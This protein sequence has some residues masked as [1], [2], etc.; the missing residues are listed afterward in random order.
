MKKH[1]LV[2]LLGTA[3]SLSACGQMGEQWLN[4]D[5]TFAKFGQPEVKGVND[6][7]EQMAKEAAQGGDYKRAAQN[8]QLLVDGNKGTPEQVLRYKLG[9]ADSL[10]RAGDYETALAMF[11]EL[12]LQNPTNVDM[13][14]G[15]GLTL[16]A[17]G[18]VADAGRAFSEV[19][20]QDPKRWRSLNALGILF[21]TKNMVPEAMAYYTEAL[22]QSPDN[23][24]ILNNVG[25]SQAVDHNYPRAIEALQQAARVSKMPSQKKQIDLNLAMVYGVSGD[26]E[27]ARDIASR[28]YEGPALDNNLGLYA[29]LSKDDNLA[30]TYFNMALSQ[31][32]T[33]YERAWANLDA[34]GNEDQ[35]TD[36]IA[37]SSNAAK[38]PKIDAAAPSPAP[39]PTPAPAPVTKKSSPNHSKSKGR[40]AVAE[41]SKPAPKSLEKKAEE[42]NDTAK[43]NDAKAGDVVKPSE[44]D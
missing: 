35:R 27:T 14:E 22:A 41:E 5:I 38:L 34:V 32:P 15:R 43:P 6:T 19:I 16:M 3:L 36:G 40:K 2:L 10:R 44:G 26:L 1:S 18:K 21:V 28:Y 31:S 23:P 7:Q 29:H 17:T 33:F 25:L 39:A 4:P 20:E 13:A 8:Y 9:W 37:P 11:E 12:H 30:K 24:A 42:A